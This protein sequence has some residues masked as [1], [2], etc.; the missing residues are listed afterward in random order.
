MRIRSIVAALAVATP[1]LVLESMP[2]A[3]C[4]WGWG[5][6]DAS[7]TAPRTYGYSGY[8]P[9]YY[10]TSYYG[11]SYYGPG[12]GW[13]GYR[14]GWRGYGYGGWRGYGFRGWR[15]VGWRGARVGAFRAGVRVGRRW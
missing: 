7:Y 9:R 1:L 12:W 8:P 15:G 13:R 10:G 2:A 5:Y 4:D 6:G 11:T 3:A 14:V